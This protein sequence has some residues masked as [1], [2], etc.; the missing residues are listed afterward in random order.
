MKSHFKIL[1]DAGVEVIYFRGLPQFT[2]PLPSRKERCRFIVKPLTNTV[3]D[4]LG[5]IR[6]E[7]KGVDRIACQ[8]TGKNK[9]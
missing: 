4:L 6:H 2:I 9:L 3:G 1:T 5:M 8:S 7:D